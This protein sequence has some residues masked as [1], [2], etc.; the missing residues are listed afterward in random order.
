MW[1]EVS[2]LNLLEAAPELHCPV[3]FFL[4]RHDH[5]VPAEFSVAYFDKLTAPSKTLIWFEDSAH[6]PFA[7]EPEKFNESMSNLVRPAIQGP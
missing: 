1:P 2:Q 7:D 3:F 6:E 5:W 4:G